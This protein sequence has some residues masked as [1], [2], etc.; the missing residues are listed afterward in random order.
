MHKKNK[1]KKLSLNRILGSKNTI[2]WQ[3]ISVIEF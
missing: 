2:Q 3:N 1:N